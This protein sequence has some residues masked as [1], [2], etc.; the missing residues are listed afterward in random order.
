V[1]FSA[2]AQTSAT[3]TVTL[4]F[5]PNVSIPNATDPGIAFATGGQS[6]T[7]NVF[8]GEKQAVF[9]TSSNSLGFQT[10]TTAG[11]LTVTVTLEGNTAQLTM[12][13][14][15]SALSLRHRNDGFGMITT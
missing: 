10:G 6:A 8:I 12:C 2:A 9:G 15:T 3:R 1:N 7:F 14:F 13:S 4:A 11:T 5:V